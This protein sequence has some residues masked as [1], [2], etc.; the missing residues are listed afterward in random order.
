MPSGGV[1]IDTPGMRGIALWDATDGIASA[2]PDIDAL[3]DRCRFRDCTHTSEPGCAVIAAVEAGLLPRRRLD[4]YLMLQAELVS[5]AHRQ[6]QKA[7]ASKEQAGKDISKAAKRF[8][9]DNPGKKSR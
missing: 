5:L 4:S 6:D 1:L 2:F 9:K 7:W 3:S 8:F